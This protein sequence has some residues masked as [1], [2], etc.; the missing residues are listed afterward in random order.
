MKNFSRILS[1]SVSFAALTI[2]MVGFQNCSVRRLEAAPG[3]SVQNQNIGAGGSSSLG[4][5]TNKQ[6]GPVV[7]STPGPVVGSTPRPMSTPAPTPVPESCLIGAETS[8]TVMGIT[9]QPAIQ[10]SFSMVMR[11]EAMGQFVPAS[12]SITTS[13]IAECARKKDFEGTNSCPKDPRPACESK[14]S[15][16]ISITLKCDGS[17]KDAAECTNFKDKVDTEIALSDAT[18]GNFI[19][20]AA[21]NIGDTCDQATMTTYMPLLFGGPKVGKIK[22]TKHEGLADGKTFTVKLIGVELVKGGT[23]TTKK[24]T[25]DGTYA[26]EIVPMPKCN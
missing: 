18:L 4:G 19:S 24:I 6:P 16:S 2:T 1:L 20:I 11:Q 10:S 13:A 15:F 23:D 12:T 21:T 25:V 3:W 5:D 26:G 22:I 14:K 8:G 7:G 17:S 9:G